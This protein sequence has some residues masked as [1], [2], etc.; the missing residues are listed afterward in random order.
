VS[1]TLTPPTD[2]ASTRDSRSD[3]GSAARRAVV[4]WAWRLFRREWRQQLLVL[5]LVVVAVAATVIGAGVSINTPVPLAA[6]FGTAQDLATPSGSGS[7]LAA[8]IAS[9]EQ[10][11]GPVDVIEDQTLSVPGSVNTFLLRA[12]DPHGRFG[13]P[14]LSLVAGR[15]PAG[16]NEVAVTAGLAATLRIRIG[17]TMALPGANRRVVGVVENPQELSANFALVALGQVTAPSQTRVLFDAPGLA[18]TRR[19]GPTGPTSQ[20][21]SSSG[22]AIDVQI[23]DEATVN[24]FSPETISLAGLT[25]GMLLI[26]LVAVGGFTVLAHRRLRS[27]GMLAAQGATPR[28]VGLVVKANGIVVGG[29]GAVAGIGLAVAAWLAYRPRLESSVGHV[30]GV[31][32]LPWRVIVL[33]V[34]LALVATYVAATRPA[35]SIS[36]TPIVAA[37]SG[38]P[39]PPRQLRRSA[40]PGLAFLA[41]AF[42]LLGYSGSQAQWGRT[43]GAMRVM[44]LGLVALVPAIILLSPFCLSVLALLG[45]RAPVA[46]RLALRDLDRYRARSGSALAAISLG[47]LIAVI[48]AIVAAARYANALDY[49]GP[50]LEPNQL[51][52]YTTNGPDYIPPDMVAAKGDGPSPSIPT[53]PQLQAMDNAA[54]NLAALLGARQIVELDTTSAQLRHAAAGRNWNGPMFIATPA[55]LHAFGVHAAQINPDADVLTHR[56]G[57]SGLSNMQL[58]YNPTASLYQRGPGPSAGASQSD[59]PC[60][61]GQCL[62]NPV[63]QE[64]PALPSG[65]SAPNTVITEHAVERLGLP[66]ETS[67]WLIETPKP[68]TSTQIGDA[69]RVAVSAGLVVETKNDEPSSDQ[70][71]NLATLFGIGLA[72][73]IL[74]MSVGLIR[75]ETAT[76][77]RAL[78]A[79]GASSSTRRTLTAATAGGLALSGAVLGTLTGYIGVIGWLRGNS[80][81]GGI[82]ALANV[83]VANLLAILIGMPLV[84]TAIGWLLAGREPRAIAHQPIE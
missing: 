1:G 75:S 34:A 60:P 48:V 62:T 65:T 73:A 79:T 6:T 9:L 52:L 43:G 7:R 17:S 25:L 84:A 67:G 41:V 51:A 30:I 77:L 33:A 81:N 61:P 44:V 50:N 28:N 27:L 53:A 22:Q 14:L 42:L 58:L 15:Y 5:G 66:M 63:I 68:L 49:V 23:R 82:A 69:R 3:G 4:R 78:T 2:T 19:S 70:V 46:I 72:L 36:R 56:P 21:T 26:A 18:A 37:L 40:L 80:L 8:Q 59:F 35:R 12:Q 10:R 39:T 76:D 64:V 71:I 54:H 11:Y 45:R 24:G 83:P 13:G 38:R 31:W 29:V 47:V 32:A 20:I 57:I 55:L 16:A 74:A